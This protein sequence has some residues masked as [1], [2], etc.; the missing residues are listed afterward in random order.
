MKVNIKTGVY[1]FQKGEK[2][3]FDDLGEKNEKLDLEKA[4]VFIL[5]DTFIKS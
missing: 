4:I 3:I 1:T 5:F 2:R